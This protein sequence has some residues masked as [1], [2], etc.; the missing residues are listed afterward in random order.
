MN[1]DEDKRKEMAKNKY[2]SL[3]QCVWLAA[4]EWLLDLQVL[5][6]VIAYLVLLPWRFIELRNIAVSQYCE[7]PAN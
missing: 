2:L 7:V 4:V 6:F 3:K 1:G 5:P